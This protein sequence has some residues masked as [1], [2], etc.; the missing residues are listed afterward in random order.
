MILERSKNSS[1]MRCSMTLQLSAMW[2]KHE[3]HLY[4]FGEPMKPPPKPPMIAA[5]SSIK[6]LFVAAVIVIG[7]VTALMLLI[8][9]LGT[10]TR[11]GSCW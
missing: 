9:V 7:S 1:P 4:R 6:E 8:F 5:P 2:R 10:A 3:T 11:H